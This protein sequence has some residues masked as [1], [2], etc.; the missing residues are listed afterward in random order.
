MARCRIHLGAEFA[1]AR[2]DN[3]RILGVVEMVQKD[4][5]ICPSE[6]CQCVENANSIGPAA[7]MK[8][9]P[10]PLIVVPLTV[11]D[12]DHRPELNHVGSK[13]KR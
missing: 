10:M 12:G 7:K 2:S 1:W 9:G 11:L 5:E 3:I 4:Q 6:L 8:D 13:E